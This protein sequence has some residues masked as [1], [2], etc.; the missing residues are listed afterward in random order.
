MAANSNPGSSLRLRPLLELL[1]R[2]AVDFIVIGGIAG[3]VHGSAHPTFDFD[4][5]YARDEQ[6]L[7][8]MAV[9]LAELGVTLRGAP[10]DLPFQID[11]RTLAAGCNFTFVSEYGSFD[12]LG[13]A[14]GMRDYEVMRADSKK[15][16]LWGVPVRVASIDDLIRMKRAAGRPK[17]K[18]MAEELIALA[19]D[20]RRRNSGS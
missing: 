6:N 5:V 12:I 10:A 8:R 14:A 4:V 15:E 16:T 2:H 3:I 9:A 1:N 11:A 7:E 17:D 18:A 19:E 20:Q 13:D